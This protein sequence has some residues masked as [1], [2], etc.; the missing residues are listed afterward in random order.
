MIPITLYYE[1]MS[2]TDVTLCQLMQCS[3]HQGFRFVGL[4]LETIP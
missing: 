1:I 3:N 2:D 4:Y